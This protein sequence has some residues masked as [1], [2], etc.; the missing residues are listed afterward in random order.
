MTAAVAAKHETTSGLAPF[1]LKDTASFIETQ[2]PVGRLSAE[3]YKEVIGIA[4][5]IRP[6]I[7]SGRNMDYYHFASDLELLACHRYQCHHAPPLG[8]RLKRG[9]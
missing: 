4:V 1:S 3:A 7:S 9:R 5:R 2:F 6:K 8:Y